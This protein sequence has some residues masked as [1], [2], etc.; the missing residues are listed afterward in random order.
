MRVEPDGRQD[1]LSAVQPRVKEWSKSG[2]RVVKRK[3]ADAGE[4]RQN[5]R[6]K[7]GSKRGV[8]Q[9]W[10]DSGQNEVKAGSKV[11]GEE[12]DAVEKG[13]EV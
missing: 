12:A 10:S 7:V 6:V 5:R 13:L 9:T 4:E 2:Q 11:K 3:V 8:V 1:C